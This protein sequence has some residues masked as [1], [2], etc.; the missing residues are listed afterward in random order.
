MA[1]TYAYLGL[2][3]AVSMIIAALVGAAHDAIRGAI[4]RHR[5]QRTTVLT[6]RVEQHLAAGNQT[7]ESL[8]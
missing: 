1:E 6:R 4:T 7:W 2:L 5:H 3:V 8:R